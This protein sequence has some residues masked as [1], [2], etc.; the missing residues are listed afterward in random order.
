MQSAVDFN[1][2][3]TTFIDNLIE[4]T[5]EIKKKSLDKDS[6]EKLT[7]VTNDLSKYKFMGDQ[8]IKQNYKKPVE[9][10][11]KYVIPFVD[12][13]KERNEK[14]FYNMDYDDK[15]TGTDKEESLMTSLRFKQMWKYI[16][17]DDK[18][19]IMDMMNYLCVKAGEYIKQ[20]QSKS[21]IVLV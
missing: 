8:I 20:D 11:I 2:A 3:V 17:N 1:K 16:S 14:F 7:K 19:Y 18:K 10:F 5:K 6:Q 13:I 15:V 4:L 12:K 21:N 9:E